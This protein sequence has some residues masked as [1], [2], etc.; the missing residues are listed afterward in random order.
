MSSYMVF[1]K[2]KDDSIKMKMHD[3][4]LKSGK[5]KKRRIFWIAGWRRVTHRG[6]KRSPQHRGRG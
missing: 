1:V 6:E 5:R 4:T 3:S 2:G